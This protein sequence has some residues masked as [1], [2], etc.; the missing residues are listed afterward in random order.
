MYERWSFWDSF[1]KHFTGTYYALHNMNYLLGTSEIFKSCIG[2]ERA[3]FDEAMSRSSVYQHAKLHSVEWRGTAITG[4]Q[5][6]TMGKT[7]PR[8]EFLKSNF[9]TSSYE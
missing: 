2:Y 8:E 7:F 5:G 1:Q 9:N 3:P 6:G 4:L